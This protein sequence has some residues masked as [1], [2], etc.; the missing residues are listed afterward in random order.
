MGSPV[1]AN[2]SGTRPS[3]ADETWRLNPAAA[4]KERS[5]KSCPVTL[6]LLVSHRCLELGEEPQAF[7]A[8]ITV[9]RTEGT[10]TGRTPLNL[11]LLLDRSTS[12]RGDRLHRVKEAT[13]QIIDN[14]DPADCISVVAF[15]DR[16]QAVIPSSSGIDRS[17]A[18]AVVGTIQ[19][20]GGTEILQG[21]LAARGQLQKGRAPGRLDHMVLL[22]DG[23]TYGDERY[24]LDL[25]RWAG[26]NG[27][28]ITAIGIGADWNESFLDQLAAVSGGMSYYVAD[29]TDIPRIFGDTLLRL[30]KVI[31]SSMRLTIQPHPIADMIEIYQVSPSLLHLPIESVPAT[32]NLGPLA[33]GE[34][35]SILV[36]FHVTSSQPGLTPIAQLSADAHMLAP[37]D[38]CQPVYAS[39]GAELTVSA[40]TANEPVP[41]LIVSVMRRLTLMRLQEKASADV[42]NEDFSA[43]KNK[44]EAIATQLLHLGQTQLAQVAVNQA[45]YLARTSTLSTEASKQLRYGTRAL[46]PFDSK[47]VGP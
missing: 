10:A 13:R 3:H 29:A 27:V 14:L 38:Q 30:R 40:H 23:H 35:R 44:L 26:R 28:G 36:E 8:L 47:E 15:N 20:A 33:A 43:A 24:C 4:A 17:L 19:A 2:S 16:P 11:C 31:V 42:A 41:P 22:T 9:G 5:L 1:S 21:L 7:Y 39:I 12:M 34:K 45:A 18:K 6:E 25:A 37:E 32:L 46:L